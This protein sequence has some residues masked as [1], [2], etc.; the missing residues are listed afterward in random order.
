MNSRTKIILIGVLL[1]GI[2][3]MTIVYAAFNNSWN[4]WVQENITSGTYT[5]WNNVYHDNEI[6][7]FI[8]N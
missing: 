8:M 6:S 4:V 2:I 5:D 1:V 7:C 3:S